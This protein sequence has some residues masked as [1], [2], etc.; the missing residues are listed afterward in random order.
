MLTIGD[1]PVGQLVS[2]F[3]KLP[4]T[5]PVLPR[6]RDYYE[7]LSTRQAYRDHVIAARPLT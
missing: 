7:L 6:I 4:I 3:Y 2:R 1:I 5:H